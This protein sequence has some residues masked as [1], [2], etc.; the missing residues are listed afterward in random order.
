MQCPIRGYQ[1]DPSSQP[2]PMRRAPRRGLKI[3]WG[4][5]LQLNWQCK[6]KM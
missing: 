2:F 4:I 6:M 1:N 5:F 3:L